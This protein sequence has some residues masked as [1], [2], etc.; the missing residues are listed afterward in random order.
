MIEKIS[1][2][3]IPGEEHFLDHVHPSIEANRLLALAILD[4][5]IEMKVATRAS[6]WDDA[7]ISSITERVNV[8]N[9][10]RFATV[11]LSG[12]PSASLAA[13]VNV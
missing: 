8:A 6:A 2:D 10:G 13:G 1:P 11:K 4:Q 9:D 5:M 7:V 3:G 12:S